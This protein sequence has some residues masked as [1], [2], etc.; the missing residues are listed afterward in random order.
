VFVEVPE[1]RMELKEVF[2]LTKKFRR[3]WL[4]VTNTLA[5]NLQFYNINYYCTNRLL[6]RIRLSLLVMI[7]Y[8]SAKHYNYTQAKLH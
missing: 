4:E 7:I 6:D 3:K 5:Y 1:T 8:N 2:L